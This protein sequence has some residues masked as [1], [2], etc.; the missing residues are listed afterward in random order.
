MKRFNKKL[1]IS[2]QLTFLK[3][4]SRA[5]TNGYPL[6]AALETLKWDKSL[7]HLSEDIIHHIKRGYTLDQSLEKLSF[8]P[9]I[10]SYLFFAKEH[11]DL[12]ASITKCLAIFEKRIH[13]L[14]KFTQVIRYPIILLIV[15]SI[16]FLFIQ[17]SV[18]PNLLTL[19]QQHEQNSFIIHSAI[20]LSSLLYY[21]TILILIILFIMYWIW[22]QIKATIPIGL[23]IKIYR[24]TPLYRNY[25]TLNTSFLFATHVESLLKTGLPIKDVLTILS[26]QEKLPLLS[27]YS[28]Q[29]TNGLNHGVP[30][31]QLMTE[32]TFIS[33]QLAS[34]FQQNSNADTLEKDLATYSAYITEEINE[35]IVK[36]ITYIQ[37]VFFILLGLVI[38]LIYL[39]L[40][41]PMYQFIET[42]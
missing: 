29:L 7:F 32:L 18:V 40:L 9:I 33:P 14:K 8:H 6:L 24:S 34:I 26:K 36:F 17:H 21:S 2:T 11:G 35:K 39:S 42:I 10:T 23:Q 41:V 13:H 28:T 1:N 22:K 20:R 37:P 27:Y 5:L 15:F 4:L 31:S 25:L 30:I 3:R 12:D 16:A 19:F 38:I